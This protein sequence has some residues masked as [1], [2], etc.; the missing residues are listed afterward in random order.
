MQRIS[1]HVLLTSTK[2]K[3]ISLELIQNDC[4][5]FHNSFLH[6]S[7]L[8]VLFNLMVFRGAYNMNFEFA[9]GLSTLYR[10]SMILWRRGRPVPPQYE[11]PQAHK[12]H[13]TQHFMTIDFFN[14]VCLQ[15]RFFTFSFLILHFSI[16]YKKFTTSVLWI[17]GSKKSKN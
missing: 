8:L 3:Q 9:K 1:L 17:L 11:A 12:D 13:F 15:Y 10:C 16:K 7:P 6:Y 2:G 4:F 14:F 5:I